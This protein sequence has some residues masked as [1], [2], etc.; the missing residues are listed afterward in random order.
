MAQ[1]AAPRAA[2][3]TVGASFRHWSLG[4][5]EPDVVDAEAACR[6]VALALAAE[7]PPGEARPE[8]DC[9]EAVL[10]ERLGDPGG[11]SDVV[12]TPELSDLVVLNQAPVRD[13][14]ALR[15]ARE[16]VDVAVTRALAGRDA[17]PPGTAW[18]L[19]GHLWYRAGSALGWH[20]N[21]RVPGWRAY[22]SWVPEPDRSYFRYRDPADGRVVTS[23]DTGLDLRLFHVSADEV[24]WHCVWA[25]TERH[26]LGYRLVDAPT[27]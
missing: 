27:G 12:T 11:W 23:W 2:L 24:L 5:D 25:A 17:C 22:L 4:D 7:V 1:P 3:R 16:D 15:P 14:P 10:A 13:D 9:G 8:A 19:S 21:G 26:S 20:T 18:N 6:R